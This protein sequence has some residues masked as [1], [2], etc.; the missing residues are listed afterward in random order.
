[1]N[2]SHVFAL[3][4]ESKQEAHN[5]GICINLIQGLSPAE[6][7]VPRDHSGPAKKSNVLGKVH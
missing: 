1:M 4:L 5:L 3:P 6:N 2:P 7:T